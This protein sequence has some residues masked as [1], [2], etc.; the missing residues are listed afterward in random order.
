MYLKFCINTWLQWTATWF[1]LRQQLSS[2]SFQKCGR[3]VVNASISPT[4]G[5]TTRVMHNFFS[6]Q[7][8]SLWSQGGITAI[9]QGAMKNWRH[10]PDLCSFPRKNG[11]IWRHWSLV[12]GLIWEPALVL[13]TSW[14]NMKVLHLSKIL[15]CHYT[16]DLHKQFCC[17]TPFSFENFL[18]TR[19][20]L[21]HTYKAFH[22]SLIQVHWF[23]FQSQLR[24]YT[25]GSVLHVEQQISQAAAGLC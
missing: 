18:Q 20:D 9:F 2:Y 7:K 5:M 3:K 12:Q 23:R 16:L 11:T 6:I 25:S 24:F 22:W 17:L 19:T 13:L 4:Q 15:H 8:V 21:D 1:L 10:C 14:G